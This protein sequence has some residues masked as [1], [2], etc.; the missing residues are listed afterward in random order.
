MLLVH[1]LIFGALWGETADEAGTASGLP[2]SLAET[3]SREDG[4][5]PPDEVAERRFAARR[6]PEAGAQR[7][8]PPPGPTFR[9][10]GSRGEPQEPPTEKR[11]A[12]GTLPPS[13]ALLQEFEAPHLSLDGFLDTH[14]SGKAWKDEV[15]EGYLTEPEVLLPLGLAVSAA[16]ISHWDRR[17][18]ARWQ[19]VLG[20]HQTYSNAGQYTLIA[21]VILIGGL[22]PGEGRNGW[23]EWCTI[24]EAYCA[25]SVTVFVLKTGVKRPRPG[26]TP[27]TGSGTHSFPSGHASSAFT[28]ATLIERNS[29]P[30]LG[31]PSYGLA[32]FTAFERVESGR[33][34]ASDVLAGA[35]IGTLS[36]GIFDSL[37]WGSGEQGGIAR[38]PMKLAL[39]MDGL[40]GFD[41][42]IAIE[43]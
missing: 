10:R 42:S 38:P 43:F 7:W 17:L 2:R 41:L 23:D 28:A 1:L 29:G 16:A 3:Y 22:L 4:P 20:G 12:S 25:S 15:W 32:A 27:G 40:K 36:A 39:D 33:H 30:L 18:Q 8:P 5:D 21:A 34:H 13:S 37:H 6:T 26:P 14:F 9:G 24:G 19:G 31:L 11:S 35:A